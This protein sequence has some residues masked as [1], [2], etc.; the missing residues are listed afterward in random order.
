MVTLSTSIGNRNYAHLNVLHESQAYILPAHWCLNLF[1]KKELHNQYIIY[2]TAAKECWRGDWRSQNVVGQT[3]DKN[4]IDDHVSVLFLVIISSQSAVQT[5]LS[6]SQ[7]FALTA[8]DVCGFFVTH[9]IVRCA[10]MHHNIIW[11]L[12]KYKINK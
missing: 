1:S 11:S 7:Y 8:F 6:Y 10:L 9:G 12:G 4:D 2:F 5:S 3:T